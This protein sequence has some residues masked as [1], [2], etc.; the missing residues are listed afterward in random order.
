MLR[1]LRN[2]LEHAG[3]LEVAR[4]AVRDDGERSADDL[5]GAEALDRFGLGH[6]R[7]LRRGRASYRQQ[8]QVDHLQEIIV[9]EQ[10]ILGRGGLSVLEEDGTAAEHKRRARSAGSPS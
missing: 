7:R 4:Y 3:D 8:R 2:V 5:V 1:I 10:I 6:D 9:G